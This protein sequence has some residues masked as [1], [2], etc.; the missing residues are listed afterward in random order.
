M[1]LCL[2]T[3]INCLQGHVRPEAALHC[4]HGSRLTKVPHKNV[5]KTSR[6]AD[7][8]CLA[9]SFWTVPKFVAMTTLTQPD[10]N[11]CRF[12]GAVAPAVA[13]PTTQAEADL[14]MDGNAT[15]VRLVLH[16]LVTGHRRL[17]HPVV[18]D[19]NVTRFQKGAQAKL[20][21]IETAA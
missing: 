19:A 20:R 16:N 8:L 1:A 12:G 6:Q 21:L 5:H 9:Q 4:W 2:N 11:P 14:L 18:R 15:L 17:I 10:G 13:G 7:L 3:R